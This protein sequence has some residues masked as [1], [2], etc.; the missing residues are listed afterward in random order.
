MWTLDDYDEDTWVKNIQRF[1]GKVHKLS[2]EK[3]RTRTKNKTNASIKNEKQMEK[4]NCFHFPQKASGVLLF[5]PICW[6][7]FN[8]LFGNAREL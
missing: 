8:L 6:R 2:G 3:E 7:I 4:I 1:E 5:K